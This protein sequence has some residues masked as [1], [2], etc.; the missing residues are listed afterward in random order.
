MILDFVQVT[1]LMKRMCDGSVVICGL[2][3]EVDVILTENHC[4]VY[5]MT[6]TCG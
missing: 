6:T 4:D 2:L 1:A 5:I 3:I